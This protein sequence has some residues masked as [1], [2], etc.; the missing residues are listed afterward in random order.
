[1]IQLIKYDI[2]LQWR[3]KFW[4]VYGIIALLYTIILLNIDFSSRYLVTVILVL[5][6][7]SVLGIMFIGAIILLEKQQNI[8]EGLLVTPLSLTRYFLS[9]AV[10]L[11]SISLAASLVI[12]LV[13]NGFIK[14][15]FPVIFTI[16]FS[17][18]MYTLFGIGFSAKVKSINQYI[19]SIMVGTS[20]IVIPVIPYLVYDNMKWLIIFPMNAAIDLMLNPVT[21]GSLENYLLD[22]IILILWCV[23]ALVFAKNQFTKHLVK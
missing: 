11:G 17:S 12:I 18:I 1:M 8:L 9:K 16:I 23:I 15:I 19:A 5:S 6:D 14:N 20:W 10:S 22:G 3:Q 4:L 7:T 13:P 2:L 21:K